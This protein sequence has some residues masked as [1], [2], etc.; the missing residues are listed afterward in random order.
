MDVN[1][2]HARKLFENATS[3]LAWATDSTRVWYLHSNGPELREADFKLLSFP[4]EKDHVPVDGSA[5]DITPVF[6]M[7]NTFD[8]AALPD[9]RFPYSV[10]GSGSIGN[11]TCNFWTT[12]YDPKTYRPLGKPRQLTHWTGFCMSEVSLTK[13]GKRLAFL[14]RSGHPVLYVADLHAGG[15]RITNERHFTGSASDEVWADWT[16]DSKALI[17]VSNRT[18]R[19]AIYRQPLTER[20][21]G[22]AGQAARWPSG[23]LRQ[24]RRSLAH[25]FSASKC[26]TVL[27]FT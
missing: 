20:E 22:T 9:R 17:F 6:G 19:A 23:M 2:N 11:E 18:G 12:Q 10:R 3:G 8:V 24:P 14:Q 26:G 25:L 13:D 7:D 5:M 27:K 21:P 1:G 15:T 16:P 4:W